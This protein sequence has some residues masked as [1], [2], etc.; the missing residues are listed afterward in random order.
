MKFIDNEMQDSG[1]SYSEVDL[2]DSINYIDPNKPFGF[3]Q[4]KYS[5]FQ[6]AQS[7]NKQM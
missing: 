4:S 1:G 6:D 2:N 3:A 5:H 7:G